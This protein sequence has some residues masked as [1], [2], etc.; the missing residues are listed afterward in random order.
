MS[1][2]AAAVVGESV[3][4]GS[5]SLVS[6]GAGARPMGSKVVVL[7]PSAAVGLVGGGPWGAFRVWLQDSSNRRGLGGLDEEQTARRLAERW[8]AFCRDRGHG[9]VGPDGAMVMPGCML[10]A[11]VEG[12]WVIDETGDLLR[13]DDNVAAI[14]SGNGFALGAMYEAQKS[15]TPPLTAGAMVRRGLRAACH[16]DSACGGTLHIKDVVL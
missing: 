10:L 16:F 8:L 5:D 3:S 1:I 15:S 9:T 7:S 12:I 2:I 6:F 11:H 13:Y 14:G 4:I